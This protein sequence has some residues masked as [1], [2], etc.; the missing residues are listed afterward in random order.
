MKTIAI[1]LDAFEWSY[2]ERLL[3]AGLLPN[4]A[5]LRARGANCRL[6][7]HV[8]YRSELSWTRFL[9]GEEPLDQRRWQTCV[10]FDPTS[11]RAGTRAA[12]IPRPFYADIPGPVIAFDLIHATLS[13]DVDGD[14]VTAWGAHSAQYPRASSPDGLLGAI[15]LRFGASPAMGNDLAFHW[16]D[17]GFVEN[18]E[19]ALVTAL[20]ARAEAGRWLMARRPDWQVFLTSMSEIHGGG[21]MFW[22]G[23]DPTHPA[24]GRL[25]SAAAGAAMDRVCIAADRALGRLLHGLGNANIV[26]F[27][28]HGMVPADDVAATVLLPDLLHRRAT[29]RTLLRGLPHPDKWRA[30][31]CPPLAPAPGE[32]WDAWM[33]SHFSDGPVA[34][35]RGAVSRGAPW[36][37]RAARKAAGRTHPSLSDL[38]HVPP[39]EQVVDDHSI[40]EYEGEI[41]Y[42][43]TSWYRRHWRT[44]P[45][46]ALPSFADGHIRINLV[47][48]EAQGVVP[49]EAYEAEVASVMSCLQACRDVRTGRPAVD[50]II[51]LREGDPLDPEGP[52]AD[53][54]VIWRDG[55]DAIEHPDLGVIGPIPSLRTGYHS[56]NGFAVLAG[57][58][59]P[60]GDLGVRPVEDLTSTIVALAGG[61]PS[62]I[63]IGRPLVGV[64]VG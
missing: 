9:T 29:G 23:V 31:G 24:Y 34:S 38:G 48:R 47:G 1:G 43:V 52:A 18:L 27:A 53:L 55:P 51:W 44:S 42:Q 20:S 58:D 35:A 57:A 56:P 49:L 17:E 25:T 22:H 5:G 62:H 50:D 41:R 19:S 11:Y 8:P 61:D 10:E 46:F 14:Q 45:A 26:V 13:D 39:P 60:A 36:L 32:P 30:E 33:R 40:A 59:I 28:L 7:N 37:E 12:D 21:H 4:L 54:M 15:D 6:A 3:D 2:A 64:P 63:G 16:Y